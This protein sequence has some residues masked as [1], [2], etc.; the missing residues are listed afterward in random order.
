MSG[1]WAEA[2]VEEWRKKGWRKEGGD[3]EGIYIEYSVE[4]I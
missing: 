3:G 1:E 4:R 2:L